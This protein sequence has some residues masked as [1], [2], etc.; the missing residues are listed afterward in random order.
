[1]K[2]HSFNQS[3]SQSDT[4]QC[5]PNICHIFVISQTQRSIK[6][7]K[8]HVVLTTVKAT[9]ADIV[10]YLEIVDTHLQQSPIVSHGH[11]RLLSQR[12]NEQTNE[13]TNKQSIH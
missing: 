5:L 3:Y 4:M 6:T 12:T 7:T 13:R 8:S 10:P 9:Q 11:F 1:M 2:I